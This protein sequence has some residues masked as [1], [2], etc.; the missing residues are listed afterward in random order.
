MIYEIARIIIN[1]GNENG[2]G[3]NM[4]SIIT[5]IQNQ[6]VLA[7]PFMKLVIY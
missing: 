3:I 7:H 2:I 1:V 4:K 5:A 6:K